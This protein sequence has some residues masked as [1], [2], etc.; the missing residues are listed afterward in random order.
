ML[1]INKFLGAN[2]TKRLFFL[3]IS[4]GFFSVTFAQEDDE[5]DYLEVAE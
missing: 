3:L 4:L 2:M 1:L 5:V